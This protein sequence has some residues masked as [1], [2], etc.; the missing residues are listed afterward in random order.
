MTPRDRLGNQYLAKFI[1]HRFNYCR[2]FLAK[3]KDVAALKFKHFLVHFDHELS[4]MITM[5]RTDG[6]GEY[7]YMDVFARQRRFRVKIAKP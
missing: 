3:T 4:C 2:V 5:L 7:E 1:D 6:P